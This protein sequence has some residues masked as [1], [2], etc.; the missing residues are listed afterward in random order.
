MNQIPSSSNND[1]STPPDRYFDDAPDSIQTSSSRLN[2]LHAVLILLLAGGLF[3][4][5]NWSQ[6]HAPHPP[7]TG[8]YQTSTPV[9]QAKLVV[10]ITG[11]VKKPGVYDLPMNARVRDALHKAG[12]VLP[13]GNPNALNLAAWVEDGSRIEVPF[14]NRRNTAVTPSA[15]TLASI[16]T[17]PN[18]APIKPIKPAPIKSKASK[19]ASVKT[20]KLTKEAAL[21]NQKINLNTA[22]LNDLMLLP[23]IGPT[24]AQKILDLRQQNGPFSSVDDLDNV[25]GIGPKKLEKLRPFATVG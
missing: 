4:L 9:A 25:P 3:S 18:L 5:G 23:G 24:M 6:S 15:T 11:A 14:K 13:G 17:K 1:D 8:L 22:S 16:T 19:A 10:H 7:P 21:S 12:G 20:P 2:W